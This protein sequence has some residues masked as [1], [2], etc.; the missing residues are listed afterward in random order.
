MPENNVTNVV[1][2]DNAGGDRVLTLQSA[3]GYNSIKFNSIQFTLLRINYI[4]YLAN[5]KLKTDAHTV[6]L[7]NAATGETQ[8]PFHSVQLYVGSHCK[9]S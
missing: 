9:I 8:M 2:I 4:H 7:S 3:A 5:Q 6:N 1:L